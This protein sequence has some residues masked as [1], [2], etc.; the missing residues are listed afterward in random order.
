MALPPPLSHQNYPKALMGMNSQI[1]AQRNW[2]IFI[3]AR[4]RQL[5]PP[6]FLIVLR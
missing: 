1:T 3:S 2:L 4:I 6:S 5:S